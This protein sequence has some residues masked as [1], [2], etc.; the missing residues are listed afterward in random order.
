MRFVT[1]TPSPPFDAFVRMFWYW[2][3]PNLPLFYERIMPKATVSL[4]VN[5]LED[6]QRWYDEPDGRSIHT[7]P[8]AMLEGA[9]SEH[10]SIDSRE[11][12]L[13]AGIEFRAGGAYPFFR[14]PAQVAEGAHL[15]LEDLWGNDARLLRERLLEAPTPE[16]S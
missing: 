9:H 15:A 16:E 13:I 12:L 7:G 8:G 3:A 4:L 1:R 5:L 2:E 10:F 14:M 11:Q 6:E